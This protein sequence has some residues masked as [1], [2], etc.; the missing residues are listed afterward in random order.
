MIYIILSCIIHKLFFVGGIFAINQH[1][2]LAFFGADDH[3][4]IT[5]AAH[6]VKRVTGF[7]PQR[8]FQGIFLYTFFKRGFEGM[9]DLEEAVGRT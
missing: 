1:F 9:L 2:D 6:H 3:R 5:H 7:A 4:L 8:Q